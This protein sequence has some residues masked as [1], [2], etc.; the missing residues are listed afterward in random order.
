MSR[1]SPHLHITKTKPLEVSVHFLGVQPPASPPERAFPITTSAGVFMTTNNV[2]LFLG[3]QASSE[4]RQKSKHGDCENRVREAGC[5]RA[6]AGK[7]AREPEI[8]AYVSIDAIGVICFDE[9]K[10]NATSARPV[11]GRVK[12]DRYIGRSQ[13]GEQEERS[14]RTHVKK[15][16]ENGIQSVNPYSSAEGGVEH[17]R[18]ED[19][20]QTIEIDETMVARANIVSSIYMV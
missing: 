3:N 4:Q 1:A 5:A 13:S 17:S 8:G 2:E 7:V 12:S 20:G 9:R 10:G 15:D 14:D 11:R 19:C 6:E 16:C 18:I